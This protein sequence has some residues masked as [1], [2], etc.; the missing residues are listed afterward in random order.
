MKREDKVEGGGVPAPG[1][2]SFV[3]EWGALEG[4]D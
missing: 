4:T 2:E 1:E 3:R